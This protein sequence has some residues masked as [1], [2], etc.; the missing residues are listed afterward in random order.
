MDEGL[1][2]Q[3]KLGSDGLIPAVVQS[4]TTKRVLM[5]AWMSAESLKQ[6]IEL[7]QTVFWSRSRNEIW[8]KG[9]TSG[10]TQQIHSIQLDCDG[11]T[12][13]IQVL[14]DGPA[15]HTGSQSCFDAHTLY[16]SNS[17]AGEELG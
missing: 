7:G 3:V 10:N 13:L 9:A 1:F 6:S 8:H 5:V 15:C 4:F 2:E 16:S 17:S 12:I 11:D 14:E